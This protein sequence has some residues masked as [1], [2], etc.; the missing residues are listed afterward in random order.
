MYPNGETFTPKCLKPL[1]KLRNVCGPCSKSISR[2][3]RRLPNATGLGL[4]IAAAAFSPKYYK[5]SANN[6]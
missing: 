1:K 2:M 5:N 3:M 6:T 4:D